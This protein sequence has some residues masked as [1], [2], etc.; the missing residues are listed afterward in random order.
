MRSGRPLCA[1]SVFVAGLAGAACSSTQPGSKGPAGAGAQSR[2]EA[3][4]AGDALDA[5]IADW[6][7]R[8]GVTPAAPAGDGEFLRRA[9]LDLIGRVP[10]LAEVRAYADAAPPGAGPDRRARLVDR[11][12]A[13]PEFA[14]HWA[15]VY[16]ELL[17]RTDGSKRIE[18]DDPR[19]W[20]VTAFNENRRYDQLVHEL[21]TASGTVRDNGAVA[22][23]AARARG[24]GG[25]EAVAGATARL[26]LGLNIQCAQCHD[27]PYD[28]RWKQEDFYG[29]VAFFARTRVKREKE[30]Q[31][32]QMAEDTG[33]AMNKVVT[34]AVFDQRRGEARMRP[35]RSEDEVVVQPR[36]LGA[37]PTARGGQLSD[38]RR[39]QL[40]RAV[41]ASDLF[42]KAMVA[43]TWAQL[44]GTSIAEPWDDLGA[45]NDAG[46]PA[47]LVRLAADFRAG[48]FDVKQLLRRLVLS[49]AY[50]RSSARDPAV[51]D[52]GGAAVRAFARARVRP[53]SSE[54]LFRSLIT[55]TGADQ[56]VRQ[57]QREDLAE[58]RMAQGLKEY[59]FAFEDDEMADADFDGSMPQA[60]LLMNGE[61]TNNGA[62]AAEGGVLAGI[63]AADRAPR[64]RLDAM[65]LAAY[66]RPATAAEAALLLPELDRA[67]RARERAAYEDLF[68]AL[69]TSTE[70]VTNH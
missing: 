54:Q 8:A 18:R 47:L 5:L 28:T 9:S 63:L 40:A 39:A 17:W 37:A 62:R 44:F 41:I 6:W 10:T 20:L 19:A 22:F 27:H 45:E 25:P 33:S 49:S 58:R 69:L 24:G 15:D 65:M 60:L 13:S 43:R 1:L 32:M 11:L 51:A 56:M 36:F 67:G 66:A 4:A 68:F 57:R 2:A 46:H 34:Y 48:G 12:L 52:D 42:P 50:Q 70:A 29:L 59:K 26:F 53:L 3:A 30:L 23:F 38:G 61:L 64:A 14:E 21:L 7:R 55:A 16:G 31:M 35:P